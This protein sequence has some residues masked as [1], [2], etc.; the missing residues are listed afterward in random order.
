M[1][2]RT[3]AL[4]VFFAVIASVAILPVASQ[5]APTLTIWA[6]DTRAAPLQEIGDAFT[7]EQGIVVEVVERPFDE[8]RDTFKTAA[9]AGEGADIIIG[10]HDW[11]GELVTAG[12]LA[13]VD[14]GDKAEEFVPAAV[15]AFNYEG[16]VYGMPYAMENVAFVRNPELVPEAPTTWDEV[17]EISAALM[18]S[19]DSEYGWV[20]QENDPYHF[21]GL[22]T[23]FG[24]Y[25]FGFDEMTGYD[26]SDVGIDSEGSV[27][28]LS[29]L[30]SYVA[31][32]MM[33]TGLDYDTMHALFEAGDA[34]MIITGPWAIERIEDSGV[35]FAVS[36]I[37]GQGDV[38]AGRPFLGVQGF[39]VNAFSENA[40][41]ANLFLTEYIATED[42][43]QAI[44]E[45]GNRPSAYVAVRDGVED[46]I[47]NGF[48]AAGADGLAMPA[49]PAMGAVWTYW[50]NS[51]ALVVQGETDA[52]TSFSDA[53]ESIR[54]EIADS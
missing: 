38:E 33:P 22:Q 32:G 42:V 46:E 23:A 26:P 40:E 54:S 21:F 17:A 37:P 36:A 18:E 8:I 6:D 11:L 5:D 44:F 34:A 1:K 15:N 39:M 24:G 48:A 7:E 16:T 51:V 12:L 30:E 9:P 10:A 45:S 41:L 2:L 47:L 4:M 3:V 49:I 27:A 52:A 53:A 14:L 35:P 43:M 28:A 20:I 25:V 31:D 29:F 13:E 50:G 19:G